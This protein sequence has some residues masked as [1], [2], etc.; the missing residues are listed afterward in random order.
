MK[1][2]VEQL[3][4]TTRLSQLLRVNEHAICFA[5]IKDKRAVTYQF[6]SVRGAT[7]EALAAAVRDYPNVAR[8][9]PQCAAASS[10]WAATAS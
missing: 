4:F 1:K 8:Q 7:A 6:G 2:N 9:R 3:A 10:A 5:G